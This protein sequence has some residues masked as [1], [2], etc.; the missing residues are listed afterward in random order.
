MSIGNKVMSRGL[1]A[2]VAVDHALF[3]YDFLYDYFVP[4]EFIGKI[5][6][7]KRVVVPFGV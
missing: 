5:A 7:G 6:V 2:S 1:V 3:P 4:D